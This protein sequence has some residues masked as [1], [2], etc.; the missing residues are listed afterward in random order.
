V[1]NN[2]DVGGRVTING[3]EKVCLDG[4]EHGDFIDGGS[5]T[6]NNTCIVEIT[7]PDT[8]KLQYYVSD[9]NMQL[10][11]G[12]IHDESFAVN[13]TIRYSGKW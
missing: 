3:T 9:V 6:I 11:D 8:L 2:A 5:A 4:E 1:V 10:K 13:L 12:G 7:A